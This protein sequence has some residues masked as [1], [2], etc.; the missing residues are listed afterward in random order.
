MYKGKTRGT[1]NLRLLT[2]AL[3]MFEAF[4]GL[5]NMTFAQG[6]KALCRDFRYR[7]PFTSHASRRP[8]PM[9][10]SASNVETR[11]PVGNTI[12]HQ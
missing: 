4:S 6:A 1:K 2:T 10:L 12:N 11:T 8:S 7:P 9:K 3:V 5:A